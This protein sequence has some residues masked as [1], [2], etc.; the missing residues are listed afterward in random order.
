M[1]SAQ[2]LGGNGQGMDVHGK[3]AAREGK[4]LSKLSTLPPTEVFPLVTTV[5]LFWMP[6][7]STRIQSKRDNNDLDT[8]IVMGFSTG[9][10]TASNQ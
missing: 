3:N 7:G 9:H 6:M 2:Y 4:N 10:R 1:P 5:N 8:V